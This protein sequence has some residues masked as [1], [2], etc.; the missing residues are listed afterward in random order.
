MSE[1]T[2]SKRLHKVSEYVLGGT[3]ADIG[4]DHAHLPVYL[5]KSGVCEY[6]IAGEVNEG[7]LDSA[8]ENISKHELTCK[9]EAR[10][11]N[12]LDVLADRAADTIVIAGMG[13]PLIS[14]ILEHGK[15]HLAFVTRLVLQPNVAGDHVRGWLYSNGWKLITE[16]ILEEDGHIYEIIVAEKGE[17][18]IYQDNNREKLIWLGPYLLPEKEDAFKQKWAREKKQ[19]Y[20]IQS[21]LQHAKSDSESKLQAIAKKITWLE[22]EG[23]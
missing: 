9:V 11:G 23:L 19:L 4:S 1:F 13:G 12:G 21:N 22:E 20:A 5:V 10:L 15:D 6:A 16:T 8:K 18:S 2:L 17:E 14:S 7:P 3:V